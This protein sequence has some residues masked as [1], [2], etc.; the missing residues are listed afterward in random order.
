MQAANFARNE[1]CR[2][3]VLDACSLVVMILMVIVVVDMLVMVLMRM[4]V[5]EVAV[6]IMTDPPLL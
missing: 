5:V 1:Q 4:A 6:V 3:L 2:Q